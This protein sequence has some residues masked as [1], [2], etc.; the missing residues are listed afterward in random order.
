M[1]LPSLQHVVRVQSWCAP[2]GNVRDRRSRQPALLLLAV[3][4]LIAIQINAAKAYNATVTGD[5][6][7]SLASVP[8]LGY[9]VHTS[10]Y[11]NNFTPSD[12]PSKLQASGV[13]ALRYPGGSYADAFHWQTMSATPGVSE[14]INSNDTFDNLMTK[15]AQPA[16]CGGIITC[17]YGSN[18]AGTGGG[19]PNE[20]AAWVDYA[21][22]TKHYGIKYWEIGNE[23][24][25]NGEYGSQWETDLHYTGTT[26]RAGQPALGPTAYGQNVL[27]FVSAMKAKDP[28]IKVGV[29]MCTPGSW[30]DGVS[31]DWNSNMLAA[32]GTKIDFVI[33]HWYPGG[34]AANAL[35]SPSTI[36][37]TVSKIRSLIDQYCGSNAPNVQILVTE[38]NAGSS[39]GDGPQQTLFST[40]NYLT[41][42]ENGAQNVDWLEMHSNFL[43]EGVSGLPDDTPGEGY[44]GVQLAS[45][46][47][48]VGDT[49]CAASSNN[50]LIGAH[51]VNRT[52]GSV[53]VQIINKDPSNS[54]TVTVNLSNGAFS[55]SG[56]RQDFGVG[57]FPAGS[58][59]PSSGISTST[60]SGIGANSF[61]VTV[62]AYTVSNFIIPKGT[63]S[64]PTFTA[65]ASASPSTIAPGATG[66]ITASFKDIGVAASNVVTDIEVYNSAGTKVAQQTY[67]GQNF[68]AGG[69]NTYNWSWTAPTT[70]GAYTVSLGV[71]S[72]DWSSSYYW[73]GNAATITVASGGG[74]LIANGTYTI[75]G[76]QSG[77]AVD[78][79]GATKTS[80][81]QQEIWSING[82]SNQKWTLTNLGSNVVELVNSASGLCLEVKGSSTSNGAAVDQAAYTGAANQKWTVVQV[83]SG[84][85]NLKNVNSGEML[86]VIGGKTAD[87][88]LLD[89]WPSNGGTNQQWKFQ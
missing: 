85:Y 43:S 63:V 62:P 77:K 29:V 72:S 47:A 24:P 4:G 50:S 69:T 61:T 17:N 56:T 45:S 70:T 40:D 36:A 8:P 75:V 14:Y 80:G 16:G 84:V 1:K 87:G 2:P 74:N 13:T 44:Y 26:N 65:T 28:A 6:S 73:G 86:D 48:R 15:D 37:P 76:V 79:P 81:T 22:N 35:A 21:N 10:V 23:I 19:D 41:W 34:T 3:F 78:D 42:F 25:G 11:D 38:T 52:D 68:T 7:Q 66:T 51:V 31:P 49:L 9:G 32:C 58:M 46:V 67:S 20:A 57:N 27:Q 71:F 12:L 18:S 59:W 89:Q 53:G 39:A 60:I 33:I 55:S 88:T 30:P 64:N 83:S 54:A 82:G 5:L